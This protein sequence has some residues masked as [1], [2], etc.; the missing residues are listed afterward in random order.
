MVCEPIAPI[1]M[2]D[3]ALPEDVCRYRVIAYIELVSTTDRY[4]PPSTSWMT[5][6]RCRASAFHQSRNDGMQTDVLAGPYKRGKPLT[7]STTA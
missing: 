3:V 4:V 2:E 1:Q 5:I 7:R 6:Q